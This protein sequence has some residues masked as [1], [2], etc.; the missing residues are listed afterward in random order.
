MAVMVA[1]AKASSNKTLNVGQGIFPFVIGGIEGV[2]DNRTHLSE[3]HGPYTQT[4][5]RKVDDVIRRSGHSRPNSLVSVTVYQT[6]PQ[7]SALKQVKTYHYHILTTK[8]VL[9]VLTPL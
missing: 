6:I 5:P 2:E 1:D 7:T 8:Q 3:K 9:I 4:Q